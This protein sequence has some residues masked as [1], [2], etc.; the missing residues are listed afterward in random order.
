MYRSE[1]DKA[2]A[3]GLPAKSYLFWGAEPYYVQKYTR[4]VADRITEPQ[5]RLSLYFDEYDFEAAKSYLSQASLFGDTN[6]LV[7]KH[8]RAIPKKDLDAL[9]EICQKMPN[10]YLI[11]AHLGDQK[12]AR[13]MQRA[14]GKDKSAVDVRFFAP[15]EHEAINELGQLARDL[16]VR[17]DSQAL[18]HLYHL[19][20]HD[21]QLAAAELEKL[22]ILEGEVGTKEL[23]ALVYPLSPLSK[24]ELFEA[25]FTKAP[26]A[27]H[28]AAIEAEELDPVAIVYGLQ[29][30]LQRLFSI[31]TY[32]RLHGRAEIKEILGYSPPKEV[33]ERLTR[34]ALSIKNYPEL[35]LQLQECE[36]ALKTA[37]DL[38]KKSYLFS[39]LMKLQASIR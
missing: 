2:L 35:F 4:L 22:A 27:E 13:S 37:K 6:L 3:R 26:L 24:E 11:V 14:F 31:Y 12:S 25:V 38:D 10:S 15:K 20:H 21:L 7:I 23:D 5:N 32:V 17:I 18:R 34:A 29:Y 39:C 28:L 36:H 30:Y 8:D 1:F 19:T 33:A 9:I 16:G